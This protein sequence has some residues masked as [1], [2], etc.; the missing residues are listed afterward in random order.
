MTLKKLKSQTINKTPSSQRALK[1][2]WFWI[3][4]PLTIFGYDLGCSLKTGG[5]IFAGLLM[6]FGPFFLG[7]WLIA[8]II[9]LIISLRNKNQSL[10]LVS[11]IGLLLI[12]FPV[13]YT[14]GVILCHL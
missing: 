8:L 10:I 13:S 12:S 7:L 4:I 6:I 9:L 11:K 2:I 1:T 14:A 5:N 3:I